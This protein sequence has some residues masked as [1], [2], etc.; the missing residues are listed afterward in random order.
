[1][2]LG[3]ASFEW[4]RCADAQERALHSHFVRRKRR[5]H[6]AREDQNMRHKAVQSTHAIRCNCLL[7]C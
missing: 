6:S 3:S 2:R 5:E 7:S 1:M 4:G